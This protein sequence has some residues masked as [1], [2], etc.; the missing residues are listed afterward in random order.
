MGAHVIHMYSNNINI[1]TVLSIA[2]TVPA[3]KDPNCDQSGGRQGAHDL[4]SRIPC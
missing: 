2:A 3:H 4:A 1:H